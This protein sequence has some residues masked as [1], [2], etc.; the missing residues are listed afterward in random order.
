MF[1]RRKT[2]ASN[3]SPVLVVDALGFAHRIQR[4]D[5]CALREL[6][7]R[8]DQQY[9][10]FRAKVPFAAVLVTPWGVLG[11]SDFSTF[12]LNDMFVL[13]SKQTREDLS[14][15]YLV[16]SSL[17]YQQLLLGEF[18][19]RGGLGFGL[20]LHRGDSLLGQGF[21]DAYRASEMRDESV[22]H[23][24]AIQVSCDFLATIPNSEKSWRLLC[25]YED[26]FFLN[27]RVLTDPEMREFS[28][29]RVLRLLEEAG[30]NRTKLNGTEMFLRNLEDYDAALQP[31]SRSR[32]L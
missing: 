18:V 6:G 28:D 4:A 27:P 24:C 20:V 13:F 31:G 7:E 26:C 14:F 8:L 17:L 5:A 10:A 2:K 9:Q 11:S 15:R 12:R 29:E 3:S 30:A 21:I 16:A 23:V 19:P 1:F 32:Q 22:R 25:L